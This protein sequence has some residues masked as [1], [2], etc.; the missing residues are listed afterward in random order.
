MSSFSRNISVHFPGIAFEQCHFK[1]H[2]HTECQV[3][4]RPWASRILQNDPA[5]GL[6]VKTDSSLF[7]RAKLD[8]E[9]NPSHLESTKY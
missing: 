3:L 6:E 2:G 9:Q 4:P 5:C 1:R 8:E 7:M